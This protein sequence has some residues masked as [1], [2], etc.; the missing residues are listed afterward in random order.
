M[1]NESS[2]TIVLNRTRFGKYEGGTADSEENESN[3]EPFSL[4]ALPDLFQEEPIL[5][6]L[7][8]F[9]DKRDK[10]TEE[11]LFNEF[12]EESSA[13]IRIFINL[14]CQKQFIRRTGDRLSNKK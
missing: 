10:V 5:V 9:I 4:S 1:T 2:N 14:L 13:R 11:E 7:Y 12:S 3:L 6:K 8:D